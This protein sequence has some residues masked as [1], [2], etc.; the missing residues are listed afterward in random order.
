MAAMSERIHRDVVSYVRRSGRMNAAQ[1]RAWDL[2]HDDWVVELPAGER[3]TSIATDAQ[4]DWAGVFG[5]E[6]PLL[7]EI[8]SGTGHA[9]TAL[10]EAH[11]HA[12]V[13]AFE[14]YT[15]A[16]ASTL[17]RLAR[18]GVSNVR[19]V[20]ADGAQAL[21][22]VFEPATISELWT[23][24]PDPWHKVRHHKRR[25]VSPEFAAL[26]G[27]RLVPAGRWRLATDWADYAEAMREVL[28]ADAGLTNEHDGWAPR[29]EL[30]PVTKYEQRGRSAGREIYDLSYRR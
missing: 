27:S 13:I 16:V 8:G 10:A 23:F 2:Y 19:L 14:V 11:P 26:V 28:D 9:V 3:V 4:I 7:V 6:A 20:I 15:P 22:T 24:F 29:W 30:R 21:A 18:H 25:L 12:N 1:Q 5:R 17:G